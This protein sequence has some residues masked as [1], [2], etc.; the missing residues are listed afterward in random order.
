MKI[1]SILEKLSKYENPASDLVSKCGNTL[2]KCE[3]LDIKPHMFTYA[4]KVVMSIYL[5]YVGL[6]ITFN[7]DTYTYYKFLPG[8]KLV[9]PNE[10]LGQDDMIAVCEEMA[11]L[12]EI[13]KA[14]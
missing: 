2:K 12:E 5:E 1:K 9:K 13:V 11:K 3:E 8:N 7:R 14:L 4:D 10:A 6:D